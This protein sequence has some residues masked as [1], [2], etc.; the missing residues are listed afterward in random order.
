[1]PTTVMKTKT[2]GNNPDDLLDLLRLS[3]DEIKA[4][5]ERP[6]HDTMEFTDFCAK[7]NALNNRLDDINKKAK[8]EIQAVLLKD[9]RTVSEGTN[10][11]AL[12]QKLTVYRLN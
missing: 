3:C 6:L 9:G 4:Y 1:M 8:G 2:K 7:L 5:V 11:F 12:L 10:Y